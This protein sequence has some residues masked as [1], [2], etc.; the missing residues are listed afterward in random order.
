MLLFEKAAIVHSHSHEIILL[1]KLMNEA[2]KDGNCKRDT[3]HYADDANMSDRGSY[4]PFSV[5]DKG[6]RAGAKDLGRNQHIFIGRPGY[7]H[8]R[9]TSSYSCCL[10]ISI[11]IPR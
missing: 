7:E 5:N 4:T 9:H 8:N 11:R 1:I 10:L 3:V 2:D 6:S